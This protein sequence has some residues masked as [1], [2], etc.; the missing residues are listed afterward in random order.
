MKLVYQQVGMRQS[1]K[2]MPF[3]NKMDRDI[4]PTLKKGRLR[5]GWFLI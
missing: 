3:S 1:K 5:Y 2:Q 4:Y